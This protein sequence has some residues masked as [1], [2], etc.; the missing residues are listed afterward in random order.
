MTKADRYGSLRRSI[1]DHLLLTND[2]FDFVERN[3]VRLGWYHLELGHGGNEFDMERSA[4][5][6][7][8]VSDS[9]PYETGYAP[10]GLEGG[11]NREKS[12]MDALWHELADRKSVV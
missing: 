4:W 8:R 1:N 2:V 7:R 11:I 3:L 5:T 6:Y 10:L 12:K 9:E